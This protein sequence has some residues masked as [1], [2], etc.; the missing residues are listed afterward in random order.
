MAKKPRRCLVS[1]E[2]QTRRNEGR[3]TKWV[4]LWFNEKNRKFDALE[5]RNI[6]PHKAIYICVGCCCRLTMRHSWNLL[7][8]FWR[9]V[10]RLFRRF[11]FSLPKKNLM[12]KTP[13]TGGDS[14]SMW[15]CWAVWILYLD[16]E[17]P[18]HLGV[19]SM[20][21]NLVPLIGGIGSI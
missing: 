5:F 19:C 12:P 4:G 3:S 16:F 20:E 14:K 13:S 9:E 11:F 18:I 1:L 2:G 10:W 8:F 6:H 17:S 15:T 21:W 7:L